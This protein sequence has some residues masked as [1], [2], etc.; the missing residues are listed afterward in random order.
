MPRG[1]A[2]A[3][4]A[5]GALRWAGA[6]V[7]G[8]GTSTTGSVAM[9][10]DSGSDAVATGIS[11]AGNCAL[12]RAE[13]GGCSVAVS[14]RSFERRSTTPPHI[15]QNLWPGSLAWPHAWQF[16]VLLLR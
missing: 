8:G 9:S 1:R 16:R 6:T 10:E 7:L 4:R 13:T 5:P 14:R 11:G 12:T 2:G 15:P 3:V